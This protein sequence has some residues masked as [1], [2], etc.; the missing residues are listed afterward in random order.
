MVK[1]KINIL[2]ID[3]K[4]FYRDLKD[5][6][7]LEDLEGYADLYEKVIVIGNVEQRDYF[8]NESKEKVD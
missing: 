4:L 6:E 2:G 1:D 5:D 8:K 7:R 3:Y